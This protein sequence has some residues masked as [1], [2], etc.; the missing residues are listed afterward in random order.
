MKND[1]QILKCR[2]DKELTNQR[3]IGLISVTNL[4]ED[5]QDAEPVIDNWLKIN[6]ENK[7]NKHCLSVKL[8]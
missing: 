3:N 7:F 2:N 5:Q 6:S 1:E 4:R 8:V